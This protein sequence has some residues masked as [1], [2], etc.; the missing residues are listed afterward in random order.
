M[1]AQLGKDKPGNSEEPKYWFN[2][3]SGLV[4]LGLKS[5]AP[6]RVGPF[7]TRKEA[8]NALRLIRQRSEAWRNSE[9]NDS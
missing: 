5:G 7:E 2:L 9:E 3:A 8:E 1:T 4:E 6:D